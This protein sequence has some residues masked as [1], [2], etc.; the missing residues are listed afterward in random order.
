MKFLPTKNA[1]R[2]FSVA[3]DLHG[4][5]HISANSW[6]EALYGLG[7]MHAIDRPTQLLFS[8]AVAS[9]QSTELIADKP[10]L[11][12]MDRFF[13]RA[14]LYQ[15][16]D[17]EVGNLDD[18]TFDQLTAYCEGVN[19]GIEGFRPLAADVGHRLRAA[20]LESTIRVA[21]GQPAQLRWSGRGT[22]AERTHPAG[23]DSSRRGAR[24]TARTVQ[25][26]VGRRRFRAALAA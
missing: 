14:G 12:E 17:A 24:Q 13:R 23:P 8:R 22:A 9:G 6:R 5:P 18:K 15:H 7:Y 11:L 10:E 1:R 3:R 19:D 20:A 26:A 25:P 4:V 16:L 21:D 2:R